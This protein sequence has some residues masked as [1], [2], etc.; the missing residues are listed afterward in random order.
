MYTVKMLILGMLL[1]AVVHTADGQGVPDQLL[2]TTADLRGPRP[3]K[4]ASADGVIFDFAGYG[5]AAAYV[6]SMETSQV[7]GLDGLADLLRQSGWKGAA[8][9][10]AKLDSDPALVS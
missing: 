10:A 1:L 2:R 9:L 3:V 7:D 8:E 6:S 5:G 4:P